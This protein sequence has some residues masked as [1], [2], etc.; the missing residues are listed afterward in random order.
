M[1][2]VK[3]DGEEVCPGEIGEITA[4][5]ES[6]TNGHWKMPEETERA[7]RNEWFHTGDLATLPNILR[8]KIRCPAKRLEQVESAIRYQVYEGG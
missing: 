1:R 3:E 5:G 7:V 4:Q 2:V 6:I 8:Q